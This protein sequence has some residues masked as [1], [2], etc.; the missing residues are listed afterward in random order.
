MSDTFT[1]VTRISW[2]K[3]SQS[4]LV[5]ALLGLALFFGAF[6]VL[7]W[8]EGRSVERIRTL[9]AGLRAVVEVDPANPGA[10]P[11][12]AL[13]HF[14]G[15]ATTAQT[16]RDPVFG[17]ALPG[18]LRLRR[19]VEMYQWQETKR[20]R[21]EEQLGG[22][23]VTRTTYSY[24]KDW[25]QEHVDSGRFRRPQGHE[26]PSAM[27]YAGATFTAQPIT[28]SRLTLDKAIAEKIGGWEAYPLSEG[29][30]ASMRPPPGFRLAGSWLYRGQNPDS[31]RV[32][33][34]RVRF[35][36][37][38]PGPVSVVGQLSAGRVTP[39]TMPTGTIALVESGQVD[40]AAM[41][42]HA[43]SANAF[44][45]WL[46]RLGG[47]VMMWVGLVLV[48]RPLRVLCAFVPLLG[49]IVGAGAGLLAGL[50]ALCLSLVT[51][52]LAWLAFRPVLAVVLLAVGGL[53]LLAGG[54]VLYARGSRRV[55]AAPSAEGQAARR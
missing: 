42:A 50:V 20:S 55:Q 6:F 33:D 45:T 36:H 34:V 28:V 3:R 4:A 2:M 30:A 16:V 43:K 24:R 37:V 52:A 54:R 46:M 1:E 14:W 15:Q 25:S 49:Q 39:H 29:A 19:K 51:I 27:P 47:F 5:G 21:T 26:N 13:V 22:D 18:D 40:A 41:F 7:A 38:A 48:V 9:D 10:A 8:N 53:C 32:G 17:L 31:P 11:D 23:Q 12:G 35:A 44:L